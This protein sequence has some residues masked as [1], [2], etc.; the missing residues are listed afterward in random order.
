MRGMHTCGAKRTTK[1]APGKSRI[2]GFRVI[3]FRG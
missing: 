2:L 1:L 3:G